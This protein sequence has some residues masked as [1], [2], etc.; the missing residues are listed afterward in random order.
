MVIQSIFTPATLSV[1]PVTIS[2]LVPQ[3][4]LC[5][6]I[7]N[8][9][10]GTRFA[11]SAPLRNDTIKGANDSRIDRIFTGPR[12]IRSRI[13][14]ATLSLGQILPINPPYPHSAYSLEFLGPYID[15]FMLHELSRCVAWA[16]RNWPA[17]LVN[18]C[19]ASVSFLHHQHPLATECNDI[20]T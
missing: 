12:T 18:L 6:D 8:P 7:T 14:T 1:S 3:Q 2:T 4:V 15:I 20:C 11:S 13:A 5:L 19:S 10:G 16:K 17:S 9:D